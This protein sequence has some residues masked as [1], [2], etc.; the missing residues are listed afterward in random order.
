MFSEG[1]IDMI[2]VRLVQLAALS[3]GGYMVYNWF[4][5]TEEKVEAE[6]KATIL[7]SA[8]RWLETK[9]NGL[10][11]NQI[12]KALTQWLDEGKQAP[13]LTS[14][15][16]IECQITRGATEC[17]IKVTVAL[18]QE[19]KVIAG[20]IEQKV[21]WEDLPKEVRSEFIRTGNPVQ[22][23]VIVERQRKTEETISGSPN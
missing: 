19:G 14:I 4:R 1:V 17:P 2:V 7:R 10:S 15:L 11:A 22:V 20:E 5:K 13:M 9:L 18:E 21:A 23:F 6:F 12:E 16:R 8:A 3:V